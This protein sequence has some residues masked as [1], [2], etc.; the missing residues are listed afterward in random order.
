MGIREL[1]VK[2]SQPGPRY[3]SYPTAPQWSD[4]V[5]EATYDEHLEQ[6]KQKNGPLSLYA[7]IPF[8]E[9]LCYYCGC[10]IKITKDHESGSAYVGFLLKEL[11]LVAQRMG[12]GRELGQI[13]WGGGTPTFLASP[14]MARIQAAT[15]KH[16]VIREDAEVSIEVDP[17]VTRQEQLETLASIGFNRISM[18]V[19]DFDEAVQKAIN[20][21][22]SAEMTENMLNACRKLGFRGINFD[23]IYGLP[24]QSLASFERTLDHVIRIRPDRIALYN[25]ARLPSLIKHQVILEKYPMPG[26]D[27]RVDIFTVSYDRLLKAGYRAIGMDH[28]ALETDEMFLASNNGNLFRNFQGYSVRKAEDSVGVGVSAIGE[29]TSAFFQNVKD[30]KEYTERVTNGRLATLRGLELTRDDLIRKWTIQSVMCRFELNFAEFHSAFGVDAPTYFASE[31][32]RLGE[33]YDEG[34]LVRDA[35]GLRVTELG[36]LFIRNVA[37]VFDIYLKMPQKAT[38]SRTV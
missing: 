16:F 38:Y 19:Q 15:R 17:R 29:I 30:V 1:I 32:E 28:F 13:A 11:A 8:C 5:G 21:I 18:G 20:R 35:Q 25:Y 34:I 37:M 6:F 22:Q 7:H 14:D 2:Y 26:A 9:S 31:L 4:A 27:E 3:T 24:F 23:L 36:R 12:E 10:N 33:F